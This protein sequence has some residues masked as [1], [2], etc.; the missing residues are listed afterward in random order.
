MSTAP[1]VIDSEETALN[2]L[3]EALEGSYDS[4]VIEL[5]FQNWPV[6]EFRVKGDRYNSTMT[7]SMMRSLLDIQTQLNNV[8]AEVVYGK[9]ARNLTADERASLE[10]VFKVEQGSSQLTGDLSGFFTE[11]GKNAMEKLSGTQVVG[12]V[13]GV[14]AIFGAYS[15]GDAYLENQLESK[16]LDI[17]LETDKARHDITRDL[18]KK[19][20]SMGEMQKSIA[21]AQL[22]LLRSVGDAESVELN[23]H[24]I[25]KTS[26]TEI[27]KRERKQKELVRKD[28][29]YKVT[30]LKNKADYYI[31]ELQNIIGGKGFS[32]KLF[33]GHL[34][35]GE[36][37]RILKAFSLDTAIPL[38][39]VARISDGVITSGTIVGVNDYAK[40][41]VVAK[42]DLPIK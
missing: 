13:V 4:S 28:A 1:L 24:H 39:V 16:K 3:R 5:D 10:I 25:S 30:S 7:A 34:N 32:V 35:M 23:S 14:A 6:F 8:Y 15:I 21:S 36:M 33:K 17:T 31:V 20:P 26:L 37:D 2:Q 42:A 41:V 27:N 38:N 19:F 29:S 12:M 18:I 11:L 40:D 9:T 22:N